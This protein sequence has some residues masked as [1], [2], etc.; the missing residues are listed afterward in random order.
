MPTCLSFEA[1]STTYL[2]ISNDT[3]YWQTRYDNNLD[4]N[5]PI[6][7]LFALIVLIISNKLFLIVL[8]VVNV[9]LYVELRKIMR[10][11]SKLVNKNALNVQLSRVVSGTM[12]NDELSNTGSAVTGLDLN[13]IDIINMGLNNMGSSTGSVIPRLPRKK[14]KKQR[15]DELESQKKTLVMVLWVSLVFCTS[16]LVFAIAN[17][18]LLLMPGSVYNW[19]ASAFNYFWTCVVYGSYFFV[20]MRTNKIFKKK[21]CQIFLRQKRL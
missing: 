14:K 2:T 3:W 12:G 5:Q 10:K 16:R 7:V 13:P 15:N 20:Y 4:F 11:K 6:L 8:V 9:L 18:I 1:Y 21:F 19:Y 17:L